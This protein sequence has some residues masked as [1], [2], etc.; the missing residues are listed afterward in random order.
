MYGWCGGGGGYRTLQTPESGSGGGGGGGGGNVFV[1]S[2]RPG[3]LQLHD[4]RARDRLRC[5]RG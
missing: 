1:N 4:A 2:D 5:E 3:P